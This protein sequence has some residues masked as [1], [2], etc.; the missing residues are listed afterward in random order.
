M[1][2]NTGDYMSDTVT[3]EIWIDRS[4]DG[5]IHEHTYAVGDR[6]VLRKEVQLL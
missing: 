6:F 3:V 1:S 4:K 2:L 5:Y